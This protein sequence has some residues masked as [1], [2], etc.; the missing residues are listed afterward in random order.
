MTLKGEQ[1][2]GVT[3]LEKHSE[4]YLARDKSREKEVPVTSTACGDIESS[5]LTQRYEVRTTCLRRMI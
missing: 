1:R 5:E 4:L 2:V 3:D